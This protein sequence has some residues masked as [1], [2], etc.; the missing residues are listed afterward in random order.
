MVAG[1]APVIKDQ[2]TS[3]LLFGEEP[4]A[5]DRRYRC[6]NQLSHDEPWHVVDSDAGKRCRETACDGNG[7]VCERRRRRKPVCSGDGETD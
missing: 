5:N 4:L 3:R 6:A 1:A 2:H 7:R